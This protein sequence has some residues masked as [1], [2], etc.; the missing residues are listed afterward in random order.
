MALLYFFSILSVT[1]ATI[2][3]FIKFKLLKNGD[4]CFHYSLLYMLMV[5]LDYS[6]VHYLHALTPKYITTMLVMPR[7]TKNDLISIPL[8]SIMLKRLPSPPLDV[9]F[10]VLETLLGF[11]VVPA[12]VFSASAFCVGAGVNRFVLPAFVVAFDGSLGGSEL[13]PGKTSA[14][15]RKKT[16]TKLFHELILA[17]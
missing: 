6:S 13:T 16:V 12:A 11:G 14:K 4:L 15:K 5:N 2:Q 17:E 8:F 3:Q 1:I 9:V 10:H 7:K